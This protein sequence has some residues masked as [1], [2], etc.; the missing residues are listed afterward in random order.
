MKLTQSFAAIL[1]IC[2]SAFS[3]AGCRTT[4]PRLPYPAKVACALLD[5]VRLVVRV[6]PTLVVLRMRTTTQ[7]AC[8]PADTP[9]RR[10]IFV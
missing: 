4:P 5:T 7:A 6:C 8:V 3:F 10:V 1:L 2:S 9:P